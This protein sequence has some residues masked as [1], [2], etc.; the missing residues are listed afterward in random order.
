M[1]RNILG[2]TGIE[3]TEL[4]FGVLPMG[5]LQKNLSVEEGAEILALALK[6]GINFFDTAQVYK[7][8][9]HIRRALEKTGIR[10][11][12][13][14]K[15]FAT[16]YKEMED[17]ILEALEELGVDYV[18][19]FLLH[20]AKAEVDVFEVRN[21]AL[22]CLLD[23]KKKGFLKAIGIATHNVKIVELAAHREDMDVVFPL[24]NKAGR[25]ILD[26]TAQEMERAIDRKSVV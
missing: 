11:V 15:S 17:A 5:P 14:S 8:Y 10:P 9:T 23:Y 18:D 12:I 20:A 22:Q 19:I 2:K 24:I 13:T 21:G 16:T 6:E 26:G 1:E 3:V 4:C 25:G 7:T